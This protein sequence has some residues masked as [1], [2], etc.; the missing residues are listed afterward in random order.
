MKRPL[1]TRNLARDGGVKPLIALRS[2]KKCRV[3]VVS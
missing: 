3:R 2:V 1:T